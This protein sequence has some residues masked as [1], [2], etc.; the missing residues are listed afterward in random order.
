LDKEWKQWNQKEIEY[1]TKNYPTVDMEKMVHYLDRTETAIKLKAHSLKLKRRKGYAVLQRI[2]ENQK[3]LT[4]QYE[5]KSITIIFFI[6]FNVVSG[7]ND[8]NGLYEL[9]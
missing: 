7:F 4:K 1:L 9:K 5:L 2:L 6:I 8:F 3:K